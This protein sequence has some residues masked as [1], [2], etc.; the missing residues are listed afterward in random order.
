MLNVTNSQ[1]VHFSENESIK[2][3]HQEDSKNPD[4]VK[5]ELK[6]KIYNK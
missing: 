5:L 1:I 4:L 2:N 3:S 6:D